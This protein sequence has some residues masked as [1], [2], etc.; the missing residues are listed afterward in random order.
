GVPYNSTIGKPSFSDD[1]VDAVPSGGGLLRAAAEP[2]DAWSVDLGRRRAAALDRHR[3]VN[4][5]DGQVASA[6]FVDLG[7]PVVQPEA[8]VRLWNPWALLPSGAA[9]ANSVGLRDA[10]QKSGR[11]EGMKAFTA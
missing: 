4:R 6:A 7:S 3:A 9:G 11:D 5:G 1:E 8:P 2:I 10:V